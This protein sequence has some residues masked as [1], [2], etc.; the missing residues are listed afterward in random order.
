MHTG[1][2]WKR[3]EVLGRRT[4]ATAAPDALQAVRPFKDIPGP[5]GIPILGNKFRL[6]PG[7]SK[8]E[9]QFN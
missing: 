9:A 2:K 1:C 5:K 7:F 6:I 3:L 4:L 8:Y